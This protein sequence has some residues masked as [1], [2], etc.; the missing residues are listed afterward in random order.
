[1]VKRISARSKPDAGAAA[2]PLKPRRMMIALEP[3][4]M[5]DGAMASTGAAIGAAI[6]RAHGPHHAADPAHIH[7]DAER[8]ATIAKPVA[9][10]KSVHAPASTAPQIER[11]AAPV[12]TP[13]AAVDA[14]VA[15][16]AAPSAGA[17]ITQIVFI[18]SQVADKDAL[19]AG[20]KD[21]SV[22]VVVLKAGNDGIQQITAELAKHADLKAVHIIS[23]GFDGGVELGDAVLDGSTLGKYSADLA[24]WRYALKPG[25][26][27]LLY[28]CNVAKDQTGQAFIGRLGALTGAVV[29]AS[30]D[31][32]GAASRGGNWVLEKSTGKVDV[33]PVIAKSATDAYDDL[34][35]N[36]P[37]KAGGN[38]TA[39]DTGNHPIS[40]AQDTATP[41][42]IR[43]TPT[44]LVD[45]DGGTP[46]QIRLISALGG[47]VTTTDGAAITFGQSGTL[48]TLTGGSVDL[49]FT[50]Y[51]T[52]SAAQ[53]VYVVVDAQSASAPNSGQSTVSIPVVKVNHAP[54]LNPNVTLQ[55][56]SEFI[57]AVSANPG[58]SLATLLTRAQDLSVRSMFDIDQGQTVGIAITG[59]S[60]TNGQWQYSTD[61]GTTWRTVTGLSDSNALLLDAQASTRLRF[62]ATSAWAG[63]ANVT[64]RAWDMTSGTASTVAAP[65][66]ADTTV[67]GGST[68]FSAN[69]TT[70]DA[71]GVPITGATARPTVFASG[72]VTVAPG[73]NSVTVAP[74]LFIDDAATDIINGATVTI[75]QNYQI[76]QDVLNFINQNGITGS[77]NATTGTLTLTGAA[78]IA[79]YQAALRS[80]TYGNAYQAFVSIAREVRFSITDSLGHTSDVG[81]GFAT[82]GTSTGGGAAATANDSITVNGNVPTTFSAATLLA[83]DNVGSNGRLISVTSGPGGT[84]SYDP[85]TGMVTFTPDAGFIGTATF[86][87][88]FAPNGVY[89]PN[90]GGRHLYSLL[91]WAGRPLETRLTLAGQTQP[92][93]NN[94]IIVGSQSGAVGR[95]VYIPVGAT[96]GAIYVQMISGHFWANDQLSPTSGTG[97]GT[98]SAVETGGF[99]EANFATAYGLQGYMTLVQSAAENDALVALAAQTPYVSSAANGGTVV[100]G[101]TD[102]L[103]EG[104]WIYDGPIGPGTGAGLEFWQGVRG[105]GS[106]YGGYSN[107]SSGEPNNASNGVNGEDHMQLFTGSYHTGQWNDIA[108][109]GSSGIYAYRALGIEFGGSAS[110]NPVYQTAT[111]TVAVKTTPPVVVSGT[112]GAA[113][114]VDTNKEATDPP[115]QSVQSLFAPVYQDPFY[116]LSH[117]G[118]A[119]TGNAANSADGAWQYSTDGGATWTTLAN[120][121]SDSNAVVLASTDMLRFLPTLHVASTPG[122]LTARL[123]DGTQGTT[124]DAKDITTLIGGNGAFSDNANEATLVTQV[125]ERAH[126]PEVHPGGPG[127]T[128]TGPATATLPPTFEN[129]TTPTGDT[130]HN[131]FEHT[132]YDLETTDFSI[133]GVIVI[134]NG[135][136]NPATEG[137]WQYSTDAGA[138]WIAV[139]PVSATNGFILAASDRIRFNPAPFYAGTP[140]SMTVL[141]WDGALF[142]AHTSQ[143]TTATYGA[144]GDPVRGDKGTFSADAVT[145]NTVVTVTNNAPVATGATATLPSVD[146]DTT[147]P[148]GVT[149]YNLFNGVYADQETTDFS[150]AGIAIVGNAASSTQGVWQYSDDGVVWT[151]LPS[152]SASQAF[153]L[154]ANDRLRF[155][156]SANWNGAPGALTVVLWDRSSGVD[157]TFN[158][159]TLPNISGGNGVFS[160]AAITLSTSINP[161]NDAPVATGATSVQ[162]PDQAEDTP[163]TGDTVGHI[164]GA[165]YSDVET[166]FISAGVA[167]IGNSANPLTEGVWQYSTDNSVT[168]IN[169]PAVSDGNSLILASTDRLRFQPVSNYNGTPGQLTVRL[170]DG[171]VGVADTMMSTIGRQGGSGAFSVGTVTA[172]VTIAPVNDAPVPLVG[173]A[174]LPNVNEDTGNPPGASVASL[175]ASVY[176]DVESPLSSGGIAIT[177]D[178]STAAQGTWQYST[179]G[180]AT[181]ADIGAVSPTSAFILNSTDYV[182]FVPKPLYFGAPGR[183]TTVLWDGSDGTAHSLVDTTTSEGDL[184][185]LPYSATT[186]ALVTTIDRVNHAPVVATNGGAIL[187]TVDQDDPNPPGIPLST[188]F[189]GTFSDVDPGTNVGFAITGNAALAAEGKWQYST[190]GT[191][192][193][194]LPS[195]SATNVFTLKGTDYVRFVPG[196]HY[197]GMPGQLTARLWDQSSGAPETSLDPT[198]SIGGSGAFSTDAVTRGVEVIQANHRPVA[199]GGTA[200][201]ATVA[202]DS[203]NPPGDTVAHLYGPDFS[204]FDADTPMGVAITGNLANPA[205]EGKWQYQ[206]NGSGAWIDIGA[207]SDSAALTLA[208]T[209]RIRFLPFGH[210]NGVPTGLTARLWDG[211]ADSAGRIVNTTL[212]MN[213]KGAYSTGTIAL[214]TDISPI[215]HAP[216]ATTGTATLASQSQDNLAPPGDTVTALF[217]GAYT[218]IENQA[219]AG[220][221]VIGI[222]APSDGKWQYQL[223][224]TGA[225]IDIAATVSDGNALVLTGAD[226]IRFLTAN[227]A[228]STPGGLVVRLWDGSAGTAG[229][230][231]DIS[232]QIGGQGAFSDNANEVTLGTTISAAPHA[233]VATGTFTTLPSVTRGTE[234]PGGDTVGH[235]FADVYSDRETPI[236]GGGVAIVGNA[237]NPGDGRWQYSIDNGAT[238]INVPPVSGAAAFTLVAGD[239]LRFAPSATFAGTPGALTVRLWD[240]A[241]GAAHATLDTTAAGL[242][243]GQGTFSEA[244]VELGTEI[245]A[246]APVATG[247]GVTLPAP[248]SGDTVEQLFGGV[249]SDVETQI[250]GGGVALVGNLARPNDGAWQYSTDGG[251]SWTN[252]PPVS[253]SNAFT[254]VA[255]DRLRF[256]PGPGFQGQP[257]RLTVRLWDRSLGHAHAFVDTTAPGASGGMGAFSIRTVDVF[258]TIKSSGGSVPVEISMARTIVPDAMVD[259]NPASAAPKLPDPSELQ[260]SQSLLRGEEFKDLGQIVAASI[261]ER[262]ETLLERGGKTP[263]IVHREALSTQRSLNGRGAFQAPAPLPSLFER[264]KASATQLTEGQ[265]RLSLTAS[266]QLAAS[267]ASS[268]ERPLMES[269]FVDQLRRQRD[270]SAQEAADLAALFGALG[271]R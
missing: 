271:G 13:R 245:T 83:N 264:A 231:R 202:E 94:Q 6:D 260:L 130:V 198:G 261:G 250:S 161:V 229:A 237:A 228:A 120:D 204:D 139:P 128:A 20:I 164:F 17:P 189:S 56:D 26:D 100:T 42:R 186:V 255:S 57:G 177:G 29:A 234:N 137:V 146:E 193:T 210:F 223:G 46:T 196:T 184:D 3:R 52:A 238:W 19:I 233:P 165:S 180:G 2:A 38:I 5:F 16:S 220:V 111:V 150:Q 119:I 48:L 140:P 182:R 108:P 188:L 176:S 199:T 219:F 141:Y 32:T 98:I 144:A 123:W 109:S 113:A 157:H 45:P 142:R 4:M 251:A 92:F 117:G 158:D 236:A 149:V 135:G 103:N 222:N 97:N 39:L 205:V 60:G 194:D 51:P 127:T 257:G 232:A 31:D 101:G 156:P 28:G 104:V 105:S 102:N 129:V 206:I 159:T 21:K 265:P 136:A 68:A 244:T 163:S 75:A 89:D 207:V 106:N 93:A 63:A 87:Y 67:N 18:D 215:N 9:F 246:H 213:F 14:R 270:R 124:G 259:A 132:Y 80:V 168:W 169:L 240:R 178:S 76:Q 12:T 107:W 247:D 143:D 166:P 78:T 217:G 88:Q 258:T 8:V 24:S 192:W 249:Y 30:S 175:Y 64:I 266:R 187:P 114:L 7:P 145:L 148:G 40:I 214:G 162:L 112:G 235:L 181:W 133:A 50:L 179:D 84:A 125:D 221:A 71:K 118:V 81:S 79:N 268:D 183:L 34:L 209:D 43:I 121:L 69:T 23:H 267:P 151:N 70:I 115:G 190:D 110:D 131:L 262:S 91:P 138:T 239:R 65:Q 211:T 269:S 58:V 167:I 201:L 35:A 226:K 72:V 134:D 27:L 203:T 224:G 122:A 11:P 195:V 33:A 44:T 15:A 153:T 253:N 54:S 191:S 77:F 22:E 37:P 243:G 212:S 99:E 90:F 248:L 10:S 252:V 171:N 53:L 49:N 85:L 242:T 62:N 208:A 1:M 116:A 61:S 174:A 173:T 82:I 241:T 73:A 66:F 263:P 160:S 185:A 197:T 172:R 41:T 152:V 218:D 36:A 47:T 155:V 225:W 200:T 86:T 74:S 154:T 227:G 230:G 254:L 96:Q 216:T 256:V 59:L 170:W 147:N 126:A 95:V 25:A 55:L